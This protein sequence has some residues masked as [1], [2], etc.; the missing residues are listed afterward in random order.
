MATA[1][2]RA[3]G[4][5]FDPRMLGLLGACA[6][7]SLGCFAAAWFGLDW[8]LVSSL[9]DRVASGPLHLLGGLATVALAW[10]L[11]PL[12]TS[13][14]VALFLEHVATLVEERHYPELPS[15]P[16]LSW[17]QAI[18]CSLRFFGLMLAVN[19]ALMF[20]LFAAY[21]IAYFVV[22]GWLLGREYFELV[23]LRRLSPAASRSLR[24]RHSFELLLTGIALTFLLT[25]PFV[26]LVIPILAT[27]LMVHRFE[28]WRR[29]PAHAG[30]G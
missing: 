28:Q 1:L 10:F 26:N 29:E 18:G 12:V 23:A 20:L 15:A 17:A 5:L 7:L 16:G 11:F 27:A 2:F 13:A 25:L 9:A 22:N 14:F 24:T 4:Q 30:G 6:L 19:V 21:P 3:L 8:L